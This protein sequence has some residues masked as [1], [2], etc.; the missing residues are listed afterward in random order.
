NPRQTQSGNSGATFA[1]LCPCE[2]NLK[3]N[4]VSGT[5]TSEKGLETLIFQAM[6]G[7]TGLE[8][9]S[10]LSVAAA[11]QAGEVR[12]VSPTAAGGAGWLAGWPRDYDRAH[13]LDTAQL[14]AFL[15]ATQPNELKR[16]GIADYSNKSDIAPLKF[17]A[18]LS[19][20]IGNRGVIDVLRKGVGHGAL[21]F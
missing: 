2:T 16:L 7:R 9:V 8:P 18:R 5:D 14:F 21:H 13:A 1:Q 17:L 10:G 3:Y 4:A 15:E 6:I 11:A 19:S 20:E 12:E